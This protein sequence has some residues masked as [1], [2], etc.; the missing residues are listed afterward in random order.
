[1]LL[2][3]HSDVSIDTKVNISTNSFP[4]TLLSSTIPII[5][6]TFI[7]IYGI[8]KT[9]CCFLIFKAHISANMKM[10]V[11]SPIKSCHVAYSCIETLVLFSTSLEGKLMYTVVTI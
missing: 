4:L 1:M 6:N 11:S 10:I 8:Y 9:N 5:Y 7:N 2:S 3:L